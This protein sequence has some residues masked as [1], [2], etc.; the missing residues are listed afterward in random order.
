MKKLAS[1][2]LEEAPIPSEPYHLVRSEPLE[3]NKHYQGG[4]SPARKSPTQQEGLYKLLY[5]RL[6]NNR[7]YTNTWSYKSLD[8]V[9]SLHQADI[10]MRYGQG[11]EGT[12]ISW[13]CTNRAND[14]RSIQLFTHEPFCVFCFEWKHAAASI[15]WKT[16]LM[17]S[18]HVQ[19]HS[20][21]KEFFHVRLHRSWPL[22][23]QVCLSNQWVLW[24]QGSFLS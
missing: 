21:F 2:K 3:E 5:Y 24:S 1:H 22:C 11:D 8:A 14:H 10:M 4:L 20:T 15:I 19:T 6:C 7:C 17:A 23:K 9:P 18:H 12:E 16:S 13:H